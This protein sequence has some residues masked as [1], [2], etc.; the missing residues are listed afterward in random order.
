MVGKITEIG[1]LKDETYLDWAKRINRLRYEYYLS[2]IRTLD[3]QYRIKREAI[4]EKIKNE[5]DIFS[6]ILLIIDYINTYKW[7]G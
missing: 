4:K 2:V 7:K 3:E 1:K 5:K 6:K